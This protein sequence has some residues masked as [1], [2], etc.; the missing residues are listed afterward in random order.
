MIRY[1]ARSIA[2]IVVNHVDV[3]SWG[4]SLQRVCPSIFNLKG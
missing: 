1:S 3:S 4:I 2:M